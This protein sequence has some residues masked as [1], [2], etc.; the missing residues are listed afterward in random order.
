MG[1]SARV[2][3]VR[4]GFARIF[5]RSY[6]VAGR[7]LGWVVMPAPETLRMCELIGLGFSL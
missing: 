4:D 7:P 2:V 6:L 5:S 1:N 3:N